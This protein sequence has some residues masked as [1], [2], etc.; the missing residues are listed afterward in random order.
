MHFAPAA[1]ASVNSKKAFPN[2]VVAPHLN[3]RPRTRKKQG[4]PES[5]YIERR[6]LLRIFGAAEVP[7]AMPGQSGRLSGTRLE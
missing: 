2:S 3:R 1:H 6:N 7:D 5:A 4:L